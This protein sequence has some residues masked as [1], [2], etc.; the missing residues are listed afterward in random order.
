MGIVWCQLKREKLLFA[1]KER[2]KSRQKTVSEYGVNQKIEMEMT[3]SQNV[4][5][6]LEPIN[7]EP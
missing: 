3:Y 1:S 5:Q 6:M 2:S 4:V 7:I